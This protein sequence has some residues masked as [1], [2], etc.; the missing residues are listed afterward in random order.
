[1]QFHSFFWCGNVI[2]LCLIFFL[3]LLFV[4]G[5]W[6]WRILPGPVSM[7]TAA[8]QTLPRGRDP[9]LNL[10]ICPEP[11]AA[12][13]SRQAQFCTVCDN[14]AATRTHHTGACIFSQSEKMACESYKCAVCISGW[15]T[16]FRSSKVW[17]KWSF[18]SWR[19][20]YSTSWTWAVATF[21]FSLRLTTS[22]IVKKKL[23]QIESS[24]SGW[25]KCY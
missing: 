10:N 12:L 15:V 16:A 5:L 14:S 13:I 4:A 1:M 22:D 21:H 8:L 3:I 2:E 7:R 19:D 25:E 17:E 24:L 18:L 20:A 11:T 23:Q 6:H 9:D